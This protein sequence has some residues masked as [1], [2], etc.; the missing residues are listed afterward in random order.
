MNLFAEQ[1]QD[2]QVLKNLQLPKGMGVGWGWGGG[3]EGWAGCLGLAR[4][5][6]GIWNDWPMGTCCTAQRILP[7]IL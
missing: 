4:A 1:K 6:G 5:H 2:S 3:G 7:N